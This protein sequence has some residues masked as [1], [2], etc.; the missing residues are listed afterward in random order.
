LELAADMVS[1]LQVPLRS[2]VAITTPMPSRA[3]EDENL[4]KINHIY[5]KS[6]INLLTFSLFAFFCIWLN[7]N[8]AINFL[9]INPDYLEG[10]WCFF[11]WAL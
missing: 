3:W 10:R 7:F 1:V 8:Q 4:V 6:S 9:G 2:L 11:Y 5:K